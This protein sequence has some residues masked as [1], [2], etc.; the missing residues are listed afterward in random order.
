M[1]AIDEFY[2]IRKN[3]PRDGGHFFEWKGHDGWTT[4]EELEKAIAEWKRAVSPNTAARTIFVVR[5]TAN[6]N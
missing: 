2:A 3:D 4:R 1:P 5:H 6:D